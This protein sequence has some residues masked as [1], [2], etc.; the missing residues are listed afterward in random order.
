LDDVAPQAPDLGELGRRLGIEVTEL[1]A[2]QARATMPVAGNRQPFGWL[3]GGAAAALAET[4]ASLA[5]SVHAA[6]LGLRAA[7][8]E[9]HITHRRPA[10]DGLVTAVARAVDLGPQHAVYEVRVTDAGGHLTSTAVVT[11]V[12]VEG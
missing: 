12:M 11:L 1:T 7:G 4:L 6:G 9:L 2:I 5:G 10:K 3:N 8:R